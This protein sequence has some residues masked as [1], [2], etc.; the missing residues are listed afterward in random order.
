M[1]VLG[2]KHSSPAVLDSPAT[3]S[4]EA[5]LAWVKAVTAAVP[6][7]S[8]EI[9]NQK[10]EEFVRGVALPLAEAVGRSELGFLISVKDPYAWGASLARFW[11]FAPLGLPRRQLDRWDVPGSIQPLVAR[12]QDYRATVLLA[13]ACQAFNQKHH[14]W[15]AMVRRDPARTRVVRH[16]ELLD[17]PV[18]LLQSLQEQFCLEP[19]GPEIQTIAQ[20]ADA[21]Y[22]D[23][24]GLKMKEEEF[25]ADYYRRRAYLNAITPSMRDA[26]TRGIDWKLMEEIGYRPL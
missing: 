3:G 21:V 15:L 23:Q 13:A 17:R 9:G 20:A 12:V 8:T 25:D 6:A 22:W 10:Q 1:H 2:D 5:A 26:I 11:R 19:A 24:T 7:M 16:E 14:S 4:A 18:E